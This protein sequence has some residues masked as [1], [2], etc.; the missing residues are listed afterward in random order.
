[1]CY[2]GFFSMFRTRFFKSIISSANHI[3]NAFPARLW[4]SSQSPGKRVRAPIRVRKH[5]DR[6]G[7]WWQ[8]WES[9]W[10]KTRLCR[11]A[12]EKRRRKRKKK[13]NRHS[14]PN[15]GCGGGGGGMGRGKWRRRKKRR[16][17]KRGESE[18]YHLKLLQSTLKYHNSG[19][20]HK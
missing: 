15:R 7:A 1:M 19:P 20:A 17:R 18:D 3:F 16:R 10:R 9:H 2:T 6:R 8:I 4:P 14:L 11:K 5:W 13:Q 12:D